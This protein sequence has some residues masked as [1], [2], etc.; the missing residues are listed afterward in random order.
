MFSVGAL[1]GLVVPY[2]GKPV[3]LAALLGSALSAPLI[4][5]F[6]AFL[7]AGVTALFAESEARA[8]GSQKAFVF[9]WFITFIV[10]FTLIVGSAYARAD[11][12]RQRENIKKELRSLQS[13]LDSFQAKGFAETFHDAIVSHNLDHQ[14]IQVI[15]NIEFERISSLYDSKY[16]QQLK[17]LAVKVVQRLKRDCNFGR[18]FPVTLGFYCKTYSRFRS[19][20]PKVCDRVSVS[21]F[22]ALVDEWAA[23]E[24]NVLNAIYPFASEDNDFFINAQRNQIVKD[25]KYSMDRPSP[26]FEPLQLLLQGGFI[27]VGRALNPDWAERYLVDHM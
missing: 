17:M 27:V 16:L 5:L 9:A 22:I 13:K 4:S 18:S 1:L 15:A 3:E 14:N 19:P 21:E 8:H 10:T 2:P 6:V 11:D 24:I 23:R 12:I 26:F 25:G 7:C 20:V